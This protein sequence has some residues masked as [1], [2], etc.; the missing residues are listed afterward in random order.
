MQ[1]LFSEVQKHLSNDVLAQLG[2]QVGASDLQSVSKAAGG[3]T[4]LL[5]DAIAK[6]ANDPRAGGGLYKAIEKDHDGGI[7]GNLLGVLGGQAKPN[8]PSTTNG[9]GIVNHLLGQKQLEVAQ[10]VSQYSGL[11]I[12]KSG[13][14]MQLIAPVVMGVV[15]QTKKSNGLDLGGLASVLL[16]GNRSAGPAS[17]GRS[18]GMLGRL[19][20]MDG[21]G[22]TMDDLLKIGM[23][24]LT[25]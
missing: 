24:I 3:I 11:D 7:L 23:K 17:N 8:N 21:D 2:R 12:F 10:V 15:G 18:S 1:E 6:N 5:L 13:V 9:A 25:K 4:E 20:D 14:L 16:G 19:L 22:N